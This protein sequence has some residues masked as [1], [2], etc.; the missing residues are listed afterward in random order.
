MSLL[1]DTYSPL[2]ISELEHDHE[3][4]INAINSREN[5]CIYGPTS[6]GKTT[7]VLTILKNMGIDYIYIDSYDKSM[8]KI[9]E[10]FNKKTVLSYFQGCHSVLVFDNFEPDNDCVVNQH[11]IFISNKPIKLP[12]FL[13]KEPSVDFL[14]DLLFGIKILENTDI[15]VEKI[16]N[17]NYNTFYSNLECAIRTNK[18]IE[19]LFKKDYSHKDLYTNIPLEEKFKIAGGIYDYSAFQNSYITGVETIEELADSLESI[20]ASVLVAKTKYYSVF[21]LVIPSMYITKPVH[22]LCIKKKKKRPNYDI[23]NPLIKKNKSRL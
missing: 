1:K 11:A 17:S 8:D 10:S 6:V 20:S 18:D 13:I 16:E 21:G 4:I 14:T 5:F 2:L 23:W 19:I 9:L 15:G 3:C 22:E 12:S 7:I